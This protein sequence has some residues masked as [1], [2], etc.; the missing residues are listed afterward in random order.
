VVECLA[1]GK[2]SS[3]DAAT[4]VASTTSAAST[5]NGSSSSSSSINE[6]GKLIANNEFAY[7]ASGSRDRSVRL[8][9][10]LSGQCL[11][12]FPVHDSWVRSVIIHPTGKYIISCSDDKS[13]RVLDVKENRCMR[14][15][16]DAHGHFITCLAMS[17]NGVVVSGSVDKNVSVWSCN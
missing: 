4:L 11:L 13:I 15:I 7:L 16:S 10:T 17:K 1:F 14:T 6:N 9:D 8:W 3:N 2:K 12:V 5:S